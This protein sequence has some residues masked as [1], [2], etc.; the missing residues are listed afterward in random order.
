ML[1]LLALFCAANVDAAVINT[2]VKRV[3]DLTKHVVRVQTDI[4]FVDAEQDTKEYVFGLPKDKAKHLSQL[5]AKCGKNPCEVVPATHVD[6]NAHPNVAQYTVVLKNKVAKGETG[7]VKLTSYFTRVLTPFP[8]EITQKEE[9][10]VVYEDSHL[11][12]SPYTTETQTTKVKLPSGRV[13]SFSQIQPVTRKGAMISYGPYTNAEPFSSDAKSLRVHFKNHSPFMTVTNLVRE[14]EVSMWGRVS[15]EEVYDLLH[16]GA[17]LKGGFSR[18]EYTAQNERGASF[19]DMQAYLPKDAVNVY[20]RDQIGN[21]S[22]SR[23]RVTSTRQELAFKSRF[24]IFGGWKTQ[25]YLGYSVPTHSVLSR[26]GDKFKLEIDFSTSIEGAAVDDLTVKVILPEGS[27]NL[28]AN[29]PFA[30]DSITD[31]TRRQTYLDTPLVGRPVL[32]ISKK[33]V[34]AAHNVPFE[35]TFEFPQTFMLHEPLL[36]VSAF[37]AFFLF[38][39]VIFR[40]DVSLLA[41]SNAKAKKSKTE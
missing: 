10:L 13:E 16:T 40:F 11:L 20:Y 30:V 19:H 3:L 7:H 18:Y 22:T 41:K 21:V 5:V 33:N 17:K 28:Q 34:I 8:E 37:L 15:V 23:L 27:T 31:N 14:I 29:L 32:I 39:M 38:C 35:V 1:A 9:Q 36:L 24:P 25:W 4:Q 6:A 12:L 2:S 26:D